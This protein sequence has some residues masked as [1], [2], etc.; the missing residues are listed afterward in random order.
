MQLNE[1]RGRIG[2]QL[3]SQQSSDVGEDEKRFRR[4]AIRT[5]RAHE[6]RAQA[7]PKRMLLDEPGKLG[8]DRPVG[9]QPKIGLGPV[10]DRREA[11]PL[12]FGGPRLCSG[13][14]RHV[15]ER[16]PAPQRQRGTQEFG[17][18]LG[19]PAREGEPPLRAQPFE[20]GR[21]HVVGRHPQPVAGLDVLDGA[22]QRGTQPEHL[23]LQGM[24][25]AGR[26]PVQVLDQAVD[27]HHLAG[28]DQQQRQQGTP[29]PAAEGLLAAVGTP[30]LCRAEDAE[31]HV[32]PAC[33]RG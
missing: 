11:Q 1:I 7:L 3:V 2:T 9:A 28:S 33:T 17:R 32:N 6:Q 19:I 25:R 27:A 4:T 23:G 18:V 30:H 16:G 12:E 31:P 5:Q 21:V 22:A 15:G 26:R 10:L 8:H 20:P 24:R 13:A 14:V 29:A